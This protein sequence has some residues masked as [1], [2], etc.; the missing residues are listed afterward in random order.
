[1]EGLA[2]RLARVPV[3][4]LVVYVFVPIG[5]AATFLVGSVRTG[6]IG[7]AVFFGVLLAAAAAIWLVAVM[8]KVQARRHPRS[9]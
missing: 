9:N 2:A 6:R 5:F 3:W 1:M 8:V 4:R 7:W